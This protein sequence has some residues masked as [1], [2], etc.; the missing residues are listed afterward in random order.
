MWPWL[1]W[2]NEM[3]VLILAAV[4]IHS[5]FSVALVLKRIRELEKARKED[6]S[7]QVDRPIS[8]LQ[9]RCGNL[10]Q[11]LAAT[12]F[13]L[14]FFILPELA[15]CTHCRWRQQGISLS[16]DPQQLCF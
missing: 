15:K 11:I 6:A 3:F 14:R 7:V 8:V 10:Q 1:S 16:A 5:V 12:F 4:S 13:P 2:L 9:T